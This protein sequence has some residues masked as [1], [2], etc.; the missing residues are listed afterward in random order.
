MNAYQRRKYA[1]LLRVDDF[2]TTH[3]QLFAGSA[4]AQQILTAVKAAIAALAAT[5]LMKMSASVAARAGRK[6][7]ARKTLIDLLHKA[8]HLAR[9]FRERGHEVPPFAQP[10]STSDQS[11]VTAGRQFEKDAAAAG[12][13]FSGHG[14]G[15]QVFA[16]ATAAFERATRDRGTSKSGRTEAQTRIKDLLDAALFDVRRLDVIVRTELAGD[17]VIQ[18][19][20]KEASRIEDPRR[21]RV[22]SVEPESAPAAGADPPVAEAV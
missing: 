14:L 22:A 3:G 5:D 13:V 9:M 15:P 18:A 21:P 6:R 10:S 11:L 1:V 4:V 16:D 20:W 19:V 8:S 2:G 17:N 12:D 7:A